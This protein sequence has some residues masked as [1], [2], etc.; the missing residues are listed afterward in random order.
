MTTMKSFLFVGLVWFTGCAAMVGTDPS[1]S[2]ADL[3]RTPL[4]IGS[5]TQTSTRTSSARTGYDGRGRPTDQIRTVG[6]SS[7]R[8]QYEYDSANRPSRL[9]YP[10]GLSVTY[11]Y[12]VGGKVN[13]VRNANFTY[14]TFSYTPQGLGD[15]VVYGH[16]A[17]TKSSYAPGNYR[18]VTQRTT[19]ADQ[20]LIKELSYSYRSSGNLQTFTT[21][22]GD[23]VQTISERSFEYDVVDRLT[24]ARRCNRTGI[25]TQTS[26]YSG[27][28]VPIPDGMTI[29]QPV[30]ISG[31]LTMRRVTVSVDITHPRR[32][33]LTVD[34]VG[35]NGV[36]TSVARGGSGRDIHITNL[37]VTRLVGLAPYDG[38]WL[39]EVRDGN[40]ASGCGV[41]PIGRCTGALDRW[42]LAIETTTN[43]CIASAP[44]WQAYEYDAV[45]NLTRQVR[46]DSNGN[47]TQDVAQHYHAA[48]ID[49]PIHGVADNTA[50][51]YCYDH[52]GN[53][54]HVRP[55]AELCT[56][57]G[58]PTRE[59]RYT[60][61]NHPL[62]IL[63]GGTSV[64]SYG[65]D[66]NGSRVNKRASST[67][68][69][70]LGPRVLETVGNTTTAVNYIDAGGTRVTEIL[71][72]GTVRYY[73]GD[74]L[75]STTFVTQAN[76]TAVTVVASTSYEP[77]GRIEGTP[78]PVR[79]SFTGQEY[80][81]DTQLY[82]YDA[83]LYDPTLGRFITADTIVPD[84]SDPQSL[85][86][87]SYARNN[88]LSRIDPDGHGDVKATIGLSIQSLRRIGVLP[89]RTN[90]A[91]LNRQLWLQWSRWSEA[92]RRPSESTSAQPDFHWD[93]M[94]ASTV[95]E[96]TRPQR[97][98]PT[99]EGHISGGSV[100]V[101]GWTPG[102][103]SASTEIAS[104]TAL[105]F[106]LHR[107]DPARRNLANGLTIVDENG[108]RSSIGVS[109]GPFSMT[110]DGK[111]LVS[112]DLNMEVGADN[113]LPFQVTIY[114]DD[115]DYWAALNDRLRQQ[116]QREQA[117]RYEIGYRLAHGLLR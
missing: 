9:V 12:D 15:T 51:R 66:A 1:M 80:E 6:G 34:L 112:M 45:G 57:S 91:A 20:S 5:L 70:Y 16:G 47:I 92:Q 109:V 86:R 7:H 106:G 14:A 31:V 75:G 2:A 72:D 101:A 52:N 115:F 104:V 114:G 62:E 59:I 17:R 105:S 48:A 42:S 97:Q 3:A 55:F 22:D 50:S 39:L 99:Y 98:G 96:S 87:Y 21:K 13:A 93:S 10:G 108:T 4:A 100:T 33:D 89:P 58:T 64:A 95:A 67:T 60:A 61:D 46:Y 53:L 8:F 56:S 54:T 90:S 68:T 63:N 85:N 65:Y 41:P 40:V 113:L 35:P 25:T 27:P 94:L 26:S 82:D 81:Q 116:H 76:G 36:R 69:T 24:K 79:Y 19:R 23:A 49:G 78:P 103:N 84:P 102:S 44:M 28:S 83:R 74:L 32:A 71:G 43:S 88:P 117:L 110:F 111:G 73:H 38:A 18:L 77:F 107:V 37:D 29:T 30:T 11:G